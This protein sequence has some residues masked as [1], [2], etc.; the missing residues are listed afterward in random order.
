MQCDG[1]VKEISG[2]EPNT[3]NNRMELLAVVE[4]L[5]LLKR[6]CNVVVYSDSAYVVNA[7]TQQWLVSWASNGWQ[8]AS[9]KP[10]KNRDLWLRLLELISEQHS[11][12][13]A[14]V[15]GHAD[16]ELNNRC[17]ALAKQAINKIRRGDY[18]GRTV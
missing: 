15:Q 10:V 18:H 3:T 6:Q 2:S 8:T 17:D 7:F 12:V 14:K 5:S 1:V 16:D 9:H 4:A 13:F 11:V